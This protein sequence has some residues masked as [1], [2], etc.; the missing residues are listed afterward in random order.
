MNWCKR[1]MICRD[2]ES[3]K[4]LSDLLRARS[5]CKRRQ[6]LE[7]SGVFDGFAHGTL[8]PLWGELCPRA[9]PCAGGLGLRPAVAAAVQLNCRCGHVAHSAAVRVRA[10]REVMGG[11]AD[12]PLLYAVQ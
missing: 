1:L 11:R 3:Y 10:P 7:S 9:V 12:A 8:C 4:S 5:A 6:R 2:L